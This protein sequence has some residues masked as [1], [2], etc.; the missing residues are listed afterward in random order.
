MMTAEEVKKAGTI[1]IKYV[2]IAEALALIHEIQEKKDNLGMEMTEWIEW[3]E[4][5]VGRL[6]DMFDIK[7]EEVK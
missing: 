7:E 3:G 6:C 2:P 1:E 4:D 5:V